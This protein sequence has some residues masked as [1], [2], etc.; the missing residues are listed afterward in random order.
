[1]KKI[2]LSLCDVTGNWV[3]YYAK[4]KKRYDVRLFDLPDDIRLLHKIDKPVYG[5]V[6]APPCT[7]FASSGARWKR[8]K[9]EMRKALSIVDACLRM[10]VIYKP[11][12]WAIENPVGKLVR[13]LG[14]PVM[15]FNPCDYG[16]PYTKKTCLWGEFNIPIKNPVEP[17]E[18]S[19]MHTRYGGKTEKTKYMRS[20]TP[21][22]FA[23]AFYKANR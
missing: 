5:I 22:G 10:V 13:Y 11:K 16:D 4:R 23:K 6:A 17:T 12:F 2:I 1:M 15:Y 19:K 20:I 8:T 18:G 3:Y 21:L 14:K 9:G 7:M